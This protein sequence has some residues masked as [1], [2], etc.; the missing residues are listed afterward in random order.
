LERELRGADVVYVGT[1]VAAA[2]TKPLGNSGEPRRLSIKLEVSPQI[3]FKGNPSRIKGIETWN[4]YVPPLPNRWSSF[5]EIVRTEPGD[6]LLIVGK[7]EDTV[8]VDLCSA[9]RRWDLDA[10]SEVNKVFGP[11]PR[12]FPDASRDPKRPGIHS[13]TPLKPRA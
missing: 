3:A 7:N 13:S 8:F 6:T 10:E 11:T 12:V 2:L 9:S 4:G 5:A 1:V